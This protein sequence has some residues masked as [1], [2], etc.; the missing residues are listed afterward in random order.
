MQ[1][2]PFYEHV[3]QRGDKRGYERGIEQGIERGIER[4]I[5]QGIEQGARQTSIENTLTVLKARFP[6]ADVDV[7]IPRLEAIVDLN[8]LKQVSLDASLAASFHD[9]EETLADCL[10]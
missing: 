5:E 1:E 3:I 8:E 2:S 4:G 10:S 6:D 9:F 7:L